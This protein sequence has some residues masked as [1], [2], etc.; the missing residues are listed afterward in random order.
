MIALILAAAAG[1]CLGTG[2]LL[3]QGVWVVAALGVSV[4]GLAMLG[5]QV[6]RQRADRP[7]DA[8]VTIEHERAFDSTSG[9]AGESAVADT[10]RNDLSSDGASDEGGFGRRGPCRSSSGTPYDG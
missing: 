3:E 7:L 8:E 6:W 5:F 10:D 1:A 2:I 9:D 4:G